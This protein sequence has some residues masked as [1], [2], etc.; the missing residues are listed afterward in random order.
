[1]AAR[2]AGLMRAVRRKWDRTAPAPNR[3]RVI[4]TPRDQPTITDCN[5]VLGYLD[6]G[7]LVGGALKLDAEA[8]RAAVARELAE[9]MRRSV[10]EAAFGMLRLASASMMRAIRAVSVERGRDPRQFALL[11]FGG[12][13][14]LFATAIATE[15]GIRAL[16]Y[17]RCR[18]CSAHSAC[19]SRTPNTT[20]ARACACGSTPPTQ[21]RCRGADG[22]DRSGRTPAGARRL[23]AGAARIP[24]RCAGTLRWPV[25]RNRG[26]ATER[27][28]RSWPISPSCSGRSTNATTVSARHLRSR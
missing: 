25:E 16:S 4:R 13:G 2:S 20:R 5:L 1:M 19:W 10:E 11:A 18:A 14:P 3:G 23:S 6:P 12:N 24:P 8:A 9:P 15:L 28:W 17:L 21:S 27:R 7:G 22:V 26:A